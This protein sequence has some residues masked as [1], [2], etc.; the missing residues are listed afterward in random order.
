[1][2]TGSHVNATFKGQNEKEY[3]WFSIGNALPVS[4]ISGERAARQIIEACARGD[5]EAIISVQAQLAIKMNAIFPE[6]VTEISALV[7]QILP[8]AGGIGKG[9][10]RG[11]D[12]ASALSPSILTT[13]SDKESYENNELK[14]NEQLN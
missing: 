9:Y 7:N 11:K 10:A 14:P 12:S 4:S 2:R 8:G 6:L 13:L 1:M 5:A 3:A